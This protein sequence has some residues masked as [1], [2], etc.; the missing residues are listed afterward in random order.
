MVGLAEDAACVLL[1]LTAEESSLLLLLGLAKGVGLGVGAPKMEGPEAAKPPPC[2]GWPRR[3]PVLGWFC[4]K[5][6]AEGWGLLENDAPN[7]LLL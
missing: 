4:P 2:W 5:S 1:W 6:P 3:P 7:I